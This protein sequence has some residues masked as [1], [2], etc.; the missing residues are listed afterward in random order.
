MNWVRGVGRDCVSD[1][2]RGAVII[3]VAGDLLNHHIEMSSSLHKIAERVLES[4]TTKSPVEST[5]R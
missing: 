5:L 1:D 4:T 3:D 2:E